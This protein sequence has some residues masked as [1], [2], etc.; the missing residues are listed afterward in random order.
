ML[1]RRSTLSQWRRR[2]DYRRASEE[3]EKKKRERRTGRNEALYRFQKKKEK[4]N[5]SLR[6]QASRLI[7]RR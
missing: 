7:T 2:R 5:L 3:K 4:V 1:A 6:D